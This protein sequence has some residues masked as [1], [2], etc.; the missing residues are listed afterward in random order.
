[1]VKQRIDMASSA[2]TI[3]AAVRFGEFGQRQGDADRIQGVSH[4]RA[5]SGRQ[6]GSPL[7]ER[8][9][10]DPSEVGGDPML[11]RGAV[12]PCTWPSSARVVHIT[13][14]RLWSS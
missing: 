9:L 11:Q 2:S 8:T 12:V 7:S 3:H 5:L 4:E 14:I 6:P 13:W 10:I 1:M